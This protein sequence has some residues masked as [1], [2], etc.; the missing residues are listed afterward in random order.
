MLPTPTAPRNVRPT[1]VA[2][3]CPHDWVNGICSWCLAHRDPLDAAATFT[4]CGMNAPRKRG[5]PRVSK[6][7]RGHD[8]TEPANV[9]ILSNG[10]RQCRQCAVANNLARYHE[11]K[12]GAGLPWPG[13]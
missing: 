6:C 2:G 3:Q 9:R 8:L 4:G 10:Q 11:R 1:D 12:C 7:W 5:R 13:T